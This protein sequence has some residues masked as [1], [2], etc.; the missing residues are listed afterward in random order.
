MTRT[1]LSTKVLSTTF[2]STT[3]LST[4]FLSVACMSPLDKG[5]ENEDTA[6]ELEET[7][8][9]PAPLDG[10]DAQEPSQDTEDEA[11][12]TGIELEEDTDTEV[13]DEAEPSQDTDLVYGEEVARADSYWV[14]DGRLYKGSDEVT[15]RGVSWFGFDTT[16]HALHGLWTGQTTT[17]FL[18][19]V[20]SLGF[21]AL[22]IPI[23]PESLR[24]D[25]PLPGWTGV[26]DMVT[27]R[28]LLEH[29]LDESH[30]RG[31]YVLLDHHTCS[32]AAG[33]L[34]ASP[35]A[36]S[37]YT[38]DDWLDDLEDMAELSASYDNVVG[39]DLFNEP[40]GLTWSEW[41]SM[42]EAA[43]ASVMS[44]NPRTLVFV[45]GVGGDSSYGENNPFWGENLYEAATDAPDIPVS[46]LVYSPHTYGPSVYDQSYF[47]DPSF[48]DNMPAIWDE[49]FGHLVGAHPVV[50]GEFG[51]RNTGEDAI[52]QEAFVDYMVD[53]EMSS[54]FYWSLNP[55]S[56]DTGGIL[57]DDWM[58]VDEGKLATLAPLLD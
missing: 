30:Q 13:P 34:A 27:S 54:F 16:D 8:Q 31:L 22:R 40:Y 52:W 12:D 7:T 1:P 32:S 24:V 56:G 20:E 47:S 41:R 42:S 15:L 6:V 10:D 57:L 46:R 17:D 5:V 29:L 44:I 39:I 58:T 48:P 14:Q 19:Q 21:N 33:H 9:T 25:T 49:H 4:T 43:A 26:E 23:A 50:P 38:E 51:G 36:C 3:F 28:E 37:G 2:L 11:L 45:Q 53:A 35:L 55:N 18:D